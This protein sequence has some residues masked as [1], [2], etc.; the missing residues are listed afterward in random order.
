LLERFSELGVGFL[1]IPFPTILCTVLD[2][3]TSCRGWGRRP[4]DGV[5]QPST[6][7]LL[8]RVPRHR[9]FSDLV[10][11]T[12]PQA[13]KPWAKSSKQ[14]FMNSWGSSLLPTCFNCV[15][16]MW[17][18]VDGEI[19]TNCATLGWHQIPGPNV[20]TLQPSHSTEYKVLPPILPEMFPKSQPRTVVNRSHVTFC[21]HFP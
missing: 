21:R 2:I 6:L 10:G 20:L 9:F 19:P 15:S 3:W 4:T 14:G 13:T 16:T 1:W 5:T 11:R 7:W 12:A 18:Q 8:S 17:G